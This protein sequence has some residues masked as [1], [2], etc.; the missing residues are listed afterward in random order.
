MNKITHEALYDG[1]VHK[2]SLPDENG[3]PLAIY[4]AEPGKY[5]LGRATGIRQ[6]AVL[7]GKVVVTGPVL[8]KGKPVEGP[9]DMHSSGRA[10][11]LP[12]GT[13]FSVEVPDPGQSVF[14]AFD[15]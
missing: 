14:A 11:N 4:V 15:L 9:H 5:N 10:C 1:R 12:A 13:D 3:H 8:H 2:L 7:L 6:V